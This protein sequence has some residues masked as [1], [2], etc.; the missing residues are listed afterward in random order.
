MITQQAL[1]CAWEIDVS[2]R[3]HTPVAQSA[4]VNVTAQSACSWF[5]EETIPWITITAGASGSGNGIVSYDVEANP[6]T[7]SRIAVMTIAG[8]SFTVTQSGDSCPLQ[9]QW[10]N[11]VH[12]AISETGLVGVISAPGCSWGVTNTNSWITI[13]S[14]TEQ[15]NG[16]VGYRVASNSNFSARSGV[17]NIAGAPFT[18]SQVGT[19]CTYRL[20]T[21]N[22]IHGIGLNTAVV[23]ITAGAGCSWSVINTNSWITIL[24]NAVGTGSAT[25]GY[26]FSRNTNVNGM[27]RSGT[28]N[29][30]GEILLVTQWGSNCGFSFLPVG[31]THTIGGES[32]SVT[33]NAS[34]TSCAWTI[35]NPNS[36]ITIPPPSMSG[37]GT[38]TFTYS[39]TNNAGGQ[40]RVGSF[41]V[42]GASFTVIQA[43]V[44]CI[45]AL[46]TNAANYGAGGFSGSVDVTAGSGCSWDIF[47]TNSWITIQPPLI[48]RTNNGTVNYS[49]DPNIVGFPRTGV[50]TIAGESFTV[51]QAAAQCFLSIATNNASHSNGPGTGSVV[52]SAVSGCTWTVENNNSWIEFTT[53]SFTNSGSA[54]YTVLTNSAITSRTGVV[55][56]AGHEFRIIQTGASCQFTLGTNAVF[57]SFAAGGG[58]IA[59]ATASGCVWPVSTATPWINIPVTSGTNTGVLSYTVNTNPTILVRTGYVTIAGQT[60]TVVQAGTPCSF[61][62]SHSNA[63]HSASQTSSS[64]LVSSNVGCI[65]GVTNTNT[66]ITINSVANGTVNYTVA[67]NGF[68]LRNGTVTIAGIPFQVTQ[69]GS[70]R[71]LRVVDANIARG[72]TNKV[73]VALEAI[74]SELALGFSLCFD[75][76]QLRFVEVK[77]GTAVSNLNVDL[78]IN[79][80]G[81]STGQLGLSFFSPQVFPAGSNALVE[82]FFAAMPGST[83]ANTA[84]SLCDQPLER[85]IND[86]L[87]NSLSAMYV[88]GNVTI[89]GVCTFTVDTDPLTF[90]ASGGT[91]GVG[92]IAH[93]SCSWSASSSSPWIHFTAGTNAS[94]TA[95]IGFSVDVNPSISQRTGTLIVAGQSISVTQQGQTCSYS[96]SAQT[97]QHPISFGS[98]SV[99]VT[100]LPGCGWTVNNPNLWITI[101]S[102][103]TSSGEGDVLYNVESNSTAYSRTGVVVIA[104]QSFTII[105]LG[106]PCE[107]ALTGTTN[108]LH[109][110]AAETGSVAVATAAG[111]DWTISNTNTWIRFTAGT[112]GSGAVS[113]EYVLGHNPNNVAR[114]GTVMIA[115]RPFT[116]RQ[117]ANPCPV[118]LTGNGNHG[119]N[120][121][122]NS[123]TVT[124]SGSCA[125]TV[126]NTNSWISISTNAGTGN[127]SVT[128][129][130]QANPLATIRSAVITVSGR[131]FV[132]TQSPATCFFTLTPPGFTHGPNTDFGSITIETTASCEWD[133]YNTNTWISFAPPLSGAGGA[134]LS[135]IV[136]ANP[137][138]ITRVGSVVIE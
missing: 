99:H 89:V 115:T 35:V 125:W 71:V 116:V 61:A 137:N 30:G 97:Q 62:L 107:F 135:Y 14:A 27:P 59:V 102:P 16:Y 64:V 54:S 67:T 49:A 105:Q 7:N 133:I 25:N 70:V 96:L 20:S 106:A 75:T 90:P 66:W 51:T 2:S 4:S 103:L 18:I 34:S 127:G 33:V 112:N 108:K 36:W 138:S 52:V 37:T 111:C 42:N 87:A 126:A 104:Q 47:N 94:G 98:Y 128:Y 9:L 92:V 29:F 48:N 12:R 122:T 80:S 131:E 130:A 129:I 109:G 57:H 5:V 81:A 6:G 113:V 38:V 124:P 15:G 74:T 78:N 121:T 45:F 93:S 88:N 24:S 55:T 10:S 118:T 132:V 53:T 1:V 69:A 3:Q 123:F 95:A 44:P 26:S 23:G 63:T 83:F 50:V 86:E 76:N 19:G 11:W 17:L 91:D 43:G 13:N 60:V 40:Q 73:V 22:R 110:F 58:S 101:T 21:T 32:G 119:P 8:K 56:V 46:S 72:T 100:A 39:V 117:P 31:R 65:W 79:S 134:T 136:A 85:E 120:W 114:T 28:L 41:T 77:S 84:V 68:G 82:V